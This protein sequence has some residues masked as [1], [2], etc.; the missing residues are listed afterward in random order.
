MATDAYMFFLDY[1]GQYLQS[2]SQVSFGK[3][4]ANGISD[5]FIT[6]LAA[7]V[8]NPPGSCIFEVTDYSFDIEQILSIGSQSRG[9]GAGKVSFNPF[10]ITRSI[11]KSSPVLFQNACSGKAFQTVGLG[12]R[13]GVGDDTTGQFFL[14]FLFK[15]VAVKTIS[16]AHD[17]EAPKETVAFEYGGL[18]VRY[19]V[20]NPNGQ[21]TTVVAGGWNRVKN[22]QDTTSDAIT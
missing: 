19:G 3:L 12:L 22:I 20:Q 9:A 17:E 14:S 16:W 5:P 6:A 10:Q 13:K 18:Q 8:T 7:P 4:A 1:S 2:E 21:I 11:D 15:L